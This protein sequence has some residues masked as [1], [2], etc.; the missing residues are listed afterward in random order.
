MTNT[1]TTTTRHISFIGIKAED[2][3]S[4]VTRRLYQRP[5]AFIRGKG[6]GRHQRRVYPKVA[7]LI[8]LDPRA[9]TLTLQKATTEAE[10]GV[11]PQSS[12][13]ARA[14][15]LPPCFMSLNQTH[16]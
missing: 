14:A 9:R 4:R 2:R 16:S 8:A 7:A 11:K 6:G 13:P 5:W 3:W 12:P 1:T 10:I 15:L